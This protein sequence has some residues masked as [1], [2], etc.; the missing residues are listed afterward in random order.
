[1]CS[2]DMLPNGCFKGLCLTTL[3]RVL[4]SIISSLLKFEQKNILTSFISQQVSYR[5]TNHQHH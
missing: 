3:I 5:N 1:M 4:N 2:M